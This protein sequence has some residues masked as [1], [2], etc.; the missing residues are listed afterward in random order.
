[1]SKIFTRTYRARLSDINANGQL[2]PADYARYIV[3]TAYDWAE[4]QGLGIRVSEDLGLYWIIRETEI[5]FFE[6]LHF[7]D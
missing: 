1:M 6:S 5:Q 7:M 4:I 3:D 2:A